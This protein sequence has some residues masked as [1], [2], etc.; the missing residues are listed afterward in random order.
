MRKYAVS[1]LASI[2]LVAASC[3][4]A[5]SSVTLYGTI[6]ES[7]AYYNNAGHGSLFEMQGADLES[8]KWG[9]KGVEDLGSGLKAI[10]NLENGVY[11]TGRC[12]Q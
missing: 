2:L 5:Q 4:N 9:I 10:F 11:N 6:D 1:I 12:R 3:A 8:N 7:V